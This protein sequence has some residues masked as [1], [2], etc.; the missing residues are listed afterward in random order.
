MCFNRNH[1]PAK[2]TIFGLITCILLVSTFLGACIPPSRP[3][4]TEPAPA[5]AEVPP[6]GEPTLLPTRK[7]FDPGELVEYIVQDGDTVPALAARFNTSIPE[8]QAANPVLPQTTT[9][10]PPGLPL[11][12]PIYYLPLWG[13]SFKTI[14]DY[15][16]VNGPEQQHFSTAEYLAGTG[17]WLKDFRIWAYGGWRTGAELVDYIGYS[18]SISPQFLLAL[19]EYQTGAISQPQPPADIDK[20]PLGFNRIY[21]ENLYIQLLDAADTLNAGYYGWR[22]GQLLSTDLLDGSLVRFDPWLNAGSVAVQYY[23]SQ[24]SSPVKYNYDISGRG[25]LATYTRLFG[26]IQPQTVELIPVSLNQPEFRLPFIPGKVWS[27]TGGPH[28]AWGHNQPWAAI[29]FAPPADKGGCT[30]SEEWVTAVAD[31]VIA[32]TGNGVLMLDLDSDGDERT[33][34]V[35]FYMHIRGDERAP[36]GKAVKAGDVIGHPS[37][38][39]GS[40]TGTHAHLARKYNGEWINA[41]GVLPFNLEGWIPHSNGIAYKG[42]LTRFTKTVIASTSGDSRTYIQTDK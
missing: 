27:Y 25:L 10:L 9:T 16:F 4:A 39:G 22:L 41:D 20:Y 8:I 35:V 34:W 29:D 40:S 36:Q 18:Y 28:S 26:E 15:L 6:E 23:F 38:E 2:K 30:I 7:P 21:R 42:T 12:I 31:G 32:R 33:G 14:P 11:Q 19:L 13:S 3:A 1:Y 37:C 5:P 24:I 17:G